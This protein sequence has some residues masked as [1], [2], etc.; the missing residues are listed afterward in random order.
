VG[1]IV[2]DNCT[3]LRYP[4]AVYPVNAKYAEIRGQRTYPSIGDLPEVPDVGVLLLGSERLMDALPEIVDA[5]VR[6]VVVPG[7]G[8]TESGAAADR[9]RDLLAGLRGEQ[10]VRAVGPNCMG[11]V[12]LI[13]GAA[14][15]IGTVP[16]QYIRRG[17]IAAVAQSGAIIEALVN[18]GGRVPFSTAVSSGSE[19]S[20]TTADYLRFFA[21]DDETSA[22]LAFLEGFED[23]PDF[24]AAARTLAEAGK[25]LVVCLVGRSSTAQHGILAHSGRLAPSARV[26]AAA[27]RQAGAVLVDDLDELIAA[28]EILGAGRRPAGRRVHVVT[29]SGGEG[30]LIADLAADAGL[31][32][33]PM[34]A[35]AER[36]L[37]ARWPAFHVSNPLDPWGVD[38]YPVIY[39]R[40]IQCAADEPGDILLVSQDQQLTAGVHERQLGIDLAGYLADSVLGTGKLPVLLSPS[41]QDPDPRLAEVC[42]DRGV[43]LLRGARP[44]LSALGRLAAAADPTPI[45]SITRSQVALPP[46]SEPITEHSALDVLASLGVDVPRRFVVA[47]AEDAAAMSADIKGPVVVKAMAEGMWHKT[48]LG[49]VRLGLHDPEAVYE[50][51]KE[52]LESSRAAG[53]AATLIVAEQIQ[54]TLELMVGYTRDPEFGPTTLV[55]LGGVWTEH[56]DLVSLFVGALDTGA[57]AGLLAESRVGHMLENARGGRLDASGVVRVLCAVSQLGAAHPEVTAVDINPLIVSTRRA[58]AVD[59]VIQRSAER[60]ITP[61]TTR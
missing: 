32:L 29:N 51:S 58:V 52:I 41:S 20:T 38:D 1:S 49:L 23:G 15:Y 26:S 55:G 56:L 40:A 39:P 44:A 30:N 42:R 33:P 21:E 27:L 53:L 36:A 12:D 22:V 13:T 31:L 28:G 14:P 34:S 6:A 4:G 5:G 18:S 9:L 3:A 17:T 2:V 16:H 50:A 10:G 25:P 43:V 60:Y 54:G 45:V 59:A 35:Q 57:A 37:S 8:H 48:E 47:T 11:I 61:G 24:V 7:G 19:A 46:L